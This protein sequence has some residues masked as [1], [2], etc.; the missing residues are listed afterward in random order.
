[1]LR[2]FLIRRSGLSMQP[3]E[4]EL[5]KVTVVES[6]DAGDIRRGGLV[7]GCERETDTTIPHNPR[8]NS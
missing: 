7:V 6:N 5:T 3:S 8:S 4:T 1:M 2:I